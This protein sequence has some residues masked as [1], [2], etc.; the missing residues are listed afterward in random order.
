[1]VPA[2]AGTTAEHVSALVATMQSMKFGTGQAVTRKEDDALLRGAGRYVSDH[3]PAGLLQAVVLR[4]PHAHARFR[5]GDTAKARA[6]PGVVLILTGAD[7]AGLGSLPCPSEVPGVRIEVPPY[8]ILAQ[9]EVRHVGDAIALVVATSIDRAK[10]AAEA[11]AVEWE[12]LRH[13][14]GAA[15]ALADGAPQVWPQH[16]GN[17]VFETVLGDARATARA[18]ADAAHVVSLDVV[19]QRLVANYLDTRGVI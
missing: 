18:F 10:D 19:N 7:V 9:D 5:I 16:R 14:I 8:L 3:A 17:L 6:L 2:F 4:S 15:A 1:M 11:I 13:V 12:P